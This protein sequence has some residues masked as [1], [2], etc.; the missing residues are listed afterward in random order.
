MNKASEKF[1]NIIGKMIRE[2]SLVKTPDNLT[3][4]IMNKITG[5]KAI[6]EKIKKP[7]LSKWGKV[8][9][10]VV[11]VLILIPLL[12]SDTSGTAIN[13]F[14]DYTI[15]LKPIELPN[16]GE[17]FNKIFLMVTVAGWFFVF[18]DNYLK[19]IIFR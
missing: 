19:K 6:P 5:E 14:K 17:G 1:D 12:F 10:A 18:L 8:L 4:K 2:E 3:N 16:L 13:L 11:Y 9:I 7:I 15:N